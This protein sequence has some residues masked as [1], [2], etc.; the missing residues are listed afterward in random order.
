MTLGSA[1]VKRQ[2]ASIAAVVR[3][4]G[5]MLTTADW[6]LVV[7]AHGGRRHDLVFALRPIVRLKRVGYSEVMV[8]RTDDVDGCL[9]AIASRAEADPVLANE[10]LARV[11]PVARTFA[12]GA[13]VEAHLQAEIL[14]V[15]DAL[16]DQSFHVRVERRGHK[17]LV[18]SN[19]LERRLGTALVEALRVRGGTPRV[20]FSD[21]DVIVAVEVI[22]DYAGFGLVDRACRARY[23]FVRL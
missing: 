16:V 8:G 12:L 23:P 3:L 10:I 5:T 4:Q 15:V 1:G 20:T 13:D 9:T 11:V 6:N 22:G 2:R 17:R 14:T 18:Q 19:Q 7:T 21:P